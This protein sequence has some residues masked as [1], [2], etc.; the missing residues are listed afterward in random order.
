MYLPIL[1]WMSFCHKFLSCLFD[2]DVDLFVFFVIFDSFRLRI[3][4][5]PWDWNI[6]LHEWLILKVN[7]GK[8]TIHGWYGHSIHGTGTFNHRL[9]PVPWIRNG[10]PSP[11]EPIFPPMST[12]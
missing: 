12:W 11:M 1:S 8:Y 2:L 7:V 6:S 4:Y 9:Q 5:Q 3:P 10:L